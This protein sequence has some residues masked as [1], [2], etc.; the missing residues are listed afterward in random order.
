MTRRDIERSQFKFVGRPCRWLRNKCELG[1][2]KLLPDIEI[3]GG[4]DEV[5]KSEH[6]SAGLCHPAD[7]LPVN[8]VDAQIVAPLRR[9]RCDLFVQVVMLVQFGGDRVG[10]DLAAMNF[11]RLA[12]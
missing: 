12:M 2:R 3:V 4:D 6:V 5:A 8:F 1:I 10:H 9:G 11:R 7:F